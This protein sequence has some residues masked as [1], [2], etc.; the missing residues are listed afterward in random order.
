MRVVHRPSPGGDQWT[1][2]QCY[3]YPHFKVFPYLQ[4]Y[5][6]VQ[7]YSPDISVNTVL[8]YEILCSAFAEGTSPLGGY[9]L[10][11]CF[12]EN[13][14]GGHSKISNSADPCS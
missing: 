4:Q 8:H 3:V 13:I 11:F 7:F 12:Q 14:F 10:G 2:G 5:F 9:F 6:W 1:G